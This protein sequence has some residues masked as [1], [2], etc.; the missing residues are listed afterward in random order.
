MHELIKTADVLVE[1]Y[2]TGKLAKMGLGYEDCKKI[3][4]K[5]IYA[6]ITGTF[7]QRFFA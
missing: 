3:N 2:V 4:P 5:L 1:N 7:I 6:S